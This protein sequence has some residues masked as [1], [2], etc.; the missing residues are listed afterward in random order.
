MGVMDEKVPYPF[1]SAKDMKELMIND[2]LYKFRTKDN[3][4]LSFKIE[5]AYKKLFNSTMLPVGSFHVESVCLHGLPGVGKTS[6]V[7]AAAKEVA[8]MLGMNLVENPVPPYRPQPD[9]LVIS[10]LEMSGEISNIIMGG[11]PVADQLGEKNPLKYMNKLPMYQLAIMGEAAAGI[12]LLDDFVNATPI[13]QNSALSIALEGRFQ[14][15]DLG[16]TYVAMTANLG[17]LDNSDVMPLSDPMTARIGHYYVEDTLPDFANRA[18]DRYADA[19]ADAGVVSFLQSNQQMFML[20]TDHETRASVNGLRTPFPCPRSW[21]KLINNLRMYSHRVLNSGEEPELGKLTKMAEAYVGRHAA[22]AF[23]AYRYAMM[24][25]AEPMAKRLIETG[26]LDEAKFEKLYGQ[27]LGA[28]EQDF[29]YQLAFSLAAHVTTAIANKPEDNE[30]TEM[31]MDRY[32][33][34][35]LKLDNA[36]MCLSVSEFGARLARMVPSWS[37]LN[38]QGNPDH[39]NLEKTKQLSAAIFR[40]GKFDADTAKDIT[41]AMVAADRKEGYQSTVSKRKRNAAKP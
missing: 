21:D 39:L 33:K 25:G 10:T 20:P 1:M 8:K 37:I 31:I 13:V 15:L 19:I 35:L 26:E 36:T 17:A 18:M 28:H 9:D 32:C 3:P 23:S 34:A 41:N 6:A 2:L 30:H 24:T 27:G 22:K 29:G 7:R 40:N 12:L 11:I 14:M 4:E 16:N 38:Q 5:Q